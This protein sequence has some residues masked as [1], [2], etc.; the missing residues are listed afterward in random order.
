MRSIVEGAQAMRAPERTIGRAK[1]LRRDMMLP[2]VILWTQLRKRGTDGQR[3]RRQ[4]PVGAYVLDFY[5]T[6]ARLAVEVDG[7]AHD[8]AIRALR[9]ERRD[10]WLREQAIEVLRFAATEILRDRELEDVLRTIA[11]RAKRRM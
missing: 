10:A 7:A 3:W 11:D 5:C 4:H 8:V 2:E 1:Q 6:E 9:D